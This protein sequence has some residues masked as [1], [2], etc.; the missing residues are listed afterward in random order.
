M[1][2]STLDATVVAA[3]AV[4][5]FALALLR[6][7]EGASTLLFIIIFTVFAVIPESLM[8]C[9]ARARKATTFLRIAWRSP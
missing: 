5:I 6:L 4:F 7:R 2:L 1:S 9:L 3:Y 8:V